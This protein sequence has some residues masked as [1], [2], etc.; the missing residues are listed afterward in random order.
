VVGDPIR[1]RQIL[2]NLGANAIKFTLEGS[3]EFK[4]ATVHRTGDD[5]SIR[6][7][8]V[9]TGIGITPQQ[10]TR[11]FLRFSQADASTTRR[12]GGSGLG[13]A[14][15]KS[16]VELMGGSI[17]VESEPGKG[18]A[19]WLNLKL[20]VPLAESEPVVS[21][22]SLAQADSKRLHILIA[23]DNS[24]NQFLASMILEQAGH[25]FEI[26]ANG[27]TAL[28]RATKH[29]FDM[30]LMDCQ[31]PEMDGF[32]AT[33]RIRESIR[34]SI[35]IIGVTADALIDDRG[36]CLQSG[37]NDYLAKPYRA[38]QLIEVI[39]KWSRLT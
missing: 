4:V 3:V 6:L 16:L 21:S 18:S 27:I 9:D 24:V 10:M 14:I 29:P 26:C 38:E 20:P 8:V 30:V 32:E 19:F 28:D 37:M 25:T 22:H 33:R 39:S 12:F 1:L 11:L 2:L 35:P 13:L 7:G 31:M 17:E 15:S 36:N 34:P 23:E 5:L